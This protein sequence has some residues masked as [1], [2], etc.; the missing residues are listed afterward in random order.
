[1]QNFFKFKNL[2][3]I[4]IFFSII[5]MNIFGGINVLKSGGQNEKGLIFPMQILISF[6][7]P[8]N[9]WGEIRPDHYFVTFSLL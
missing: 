7:F 6:L 5:L 4:V 9:F 3:Q 8:F 2:F 1:M